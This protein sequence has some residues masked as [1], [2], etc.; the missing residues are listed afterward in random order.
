MESYVMPI[1]FV[2][3]AIAIGRVVWSAVTSGWKFWRGRK[4]RLS[5]QEVLT[6]RNKWKLPFTEWLQEHNYEK[7]R[8]DVIIRDLKRMD[9]YPETKE[10]K[11]ISAWFRSG[12]IDTYEKGIMLGLGTY[13]LVHDEEKGVFY[14]PPKG[15]AGNVRLTLS[16]F[17]PFEGIE[18]VD[19]EGDQYYSY[20][21]IYCYFDQKDK[22]PYE[23][24]S[25]CERRSLDEHIY[26]T[27]IVSFDDVRR[28]TKK[29]G[30]KTPFLK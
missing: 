10:G 13:E 21:H 25:F 16:G 2:G 12:V 15:Q 18:S 9:T 4:R 1:P 7:L 8:T 28:E 19:W 24:I 3:E 30:I 22:Q 11:G 23:R 27:E 5:P 20:P 6:L 14:Y 29:R 17:V 26:F